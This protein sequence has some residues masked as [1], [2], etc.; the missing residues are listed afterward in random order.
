MYIYVGCRC[1]GF[2]LE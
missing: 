1:F 2:M